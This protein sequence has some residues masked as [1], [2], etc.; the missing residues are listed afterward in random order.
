MIPLTTQSVVP[1]LQMLYTLQNH[2]E[3]ET[4]YCEEDSKLYAW[5]EDTGWAPIQVEGNGIS[6]NLY[7]LNKNIVSQLPIMTMD[8]LSGKMSMI[9]DFMLSY[10]NL[11]YM[12]LC[13]E[14]NYYTIFEHDVGLTFPTFGAAVCEIISNLGDIYSIELTKEEDAI[15]LWIRPTGEEEP[16]VFYLFPYDT[17][18][19]YYG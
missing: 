12:L 2:I 7:E 6:M 15:E 18:V 4:V 16:M 8:Q 13:K 14:Y 1:S 3:G 17:G 5:Q 10:H 11:H 19:V 9:E